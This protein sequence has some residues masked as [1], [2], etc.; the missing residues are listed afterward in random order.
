MR[1]VL[2]T[3]AFLAALPAA[4]SAQFAVGVGA[5]IPTGDFDDAVDTGLH[6]QGSFNIGLPLLPDVRIDGIYQTYS[7]GDDVSTDILG[8]GV[9][10]LLDLPL[11]V[12][13]PYLLAGVGYYDV[14]VEGE[15]GGVSAEISDSE[16]GFTG[17][18]GV[19]VGLGRLG[20]FGEARVL[21]IGG[22]FDLTSIPILVGV[23]F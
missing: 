6:L 7:G 10:L 13:K 22:D 19:R 17:G 23:T 4:A 8:G 3:A 21:R 16:F 9:N 2:F 12:I 14:S 11:V 5:A 1:R 18:A 15:E 20:V